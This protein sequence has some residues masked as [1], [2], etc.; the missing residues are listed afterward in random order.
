MSTGKKYLCPINTNKN[1]ECTQKAIKLLEHDI[2]LNTGTICLNKF[3][4]FVHLY[5]PVYPEMIQHIVQNCMSK[6]IFL[7]MQFL[8]ASGYIFI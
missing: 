5:V 4:R 6:Q 1:M 3:S 7:K 8:C 2:S